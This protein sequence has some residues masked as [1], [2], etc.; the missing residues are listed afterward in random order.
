MKKPRLGAVFQEQTEGLLV[1][2]GANDFHFNAADKLQYACR[3]VRKIRR[4]GARSAN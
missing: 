4:A 1:G 3:L 2:T